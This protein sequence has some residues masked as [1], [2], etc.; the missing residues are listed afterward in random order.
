MTWARFLSR[1]VDSMLTRLQG[2]HKY[3]GRTS[4]DHVVLYMVL[5]LLPL[6]CL[7]GNRRQ[8]RLSVTFLT[9]YMHLYLNSFYSHVLSCAFQMVADAWREYKAYRTRIGLGE[10]PFPG[11]TFALVAHTAFQVEQ[12]TSIC[13]GLFHC[14]LRFSCEN[15]PLSSLAPGP[16]T[17]PRRSN[18]IGSL[19][20]SPSPCH[21]L[22]TRWETR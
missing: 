12:T 19:F 10:F 5:G 11:V 8:T 3:T 4:W 6:V 16:M 21:G 2:L 14:S 15:I 1:L 18:H 9:F 13:Y 7:P 22:W 20:R 17:A